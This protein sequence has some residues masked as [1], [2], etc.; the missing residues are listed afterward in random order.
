ME[1]ETPECKRR[2]E[3]M[4]YWI[5]EDENTGDVIGLKPEAPAEMIEEY[6]KYLAEINSSEPLIR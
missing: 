5:I 4:Q 3:L 2:I 6:Q 1:F